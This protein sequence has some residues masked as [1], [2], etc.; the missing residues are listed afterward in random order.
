[1]MSLPLAQAMHQLPP[2]Y[3][4]TERAHY[5]SPSEVTCPYEPKGLNCGFG[6][7]HGTE[8]PTS[9]SPSSITPALHKCRDDTF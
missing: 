7:G 2:D 8:R 5:G 4:F 6:T 9:P 3:V 1:M